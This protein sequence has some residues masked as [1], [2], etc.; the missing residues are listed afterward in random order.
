MTHGPGYPVFRETSE[1]LSNLRSYET[2]HWGYSRVSSLPLASFGYT[3]CR[4]IILAN[5][6]K[7]G[8]S[9]I[10]P[11]ENPEPFLA[12]ML[13]ELGCRTP[14]A[15]AI[16]VYGYYPR[17]LL[18]C[19]REYNIEIVDEHDGDGRFKRRRDVI[20]IPSL[21]EVAVFSDYSKI[22]D[23]GKKPRKVKRHTLRFP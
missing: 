1:F 23:H 12:S 15:S 17:Q 21:R 11:S 13:E 8:L 19:C 9:H 7:A 4:S 20:V 22:S 2:V 18:E 5:G 14:E 3:T 10:R 16:L 6:K